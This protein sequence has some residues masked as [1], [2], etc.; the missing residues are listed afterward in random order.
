MKHSFAKTLA[1]QLCLSLLLIRISP[2]LSAADTIQ[3]A[4]DIAPIFEQHCV[5]YHSPGNEKSNLSLATIDALKENE[6]AIAGVSDGSYLLKMATTSDSEPPKMPKDSD[7]LSAKHMAL[8]RRWINEGA[9]WP[10]GSG[11]S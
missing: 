11:F 3:F 5:R 6:Y 2:P 8:L 1:W 10:K 9:K 4:E 7:P